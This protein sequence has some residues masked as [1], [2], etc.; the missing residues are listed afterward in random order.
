MVGCLYKSHN[1][2]VRKDLST[3][4]VNVNYLYIK[5]FFKF[6]KCYARNKYY[7]NIKTLY[8]YSVIQKYRYV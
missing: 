8:K 5:K 4:I 7:N 1:H 3:C 6:I 2:Y